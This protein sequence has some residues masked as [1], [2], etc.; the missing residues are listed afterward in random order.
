MMRRGGT[1]SEQQKE[2]VVRAF[3]TM[4]SVEL[5]YST[6]LLVYVLDKFLV[7]DDSNCKSSFVFPSNILNNTMEQALIR[8]RQLHQW[9]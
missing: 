6:V 9:A 4:T 1:H 5:Q 3:V 7:M 8:G 2:Q